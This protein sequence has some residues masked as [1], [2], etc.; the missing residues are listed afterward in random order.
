M[1]MSKANREKEY[2]YYGNVEELRKR[3]TFVLLLFFHLNDEILFP[4]FFQT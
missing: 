3:I 2:C 4:P 1:Q